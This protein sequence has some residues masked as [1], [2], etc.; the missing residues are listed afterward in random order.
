[1]TETT[2]PATWE[3]VQQ[4]ARLL[5]K[6]GVKYALIG[7]YALAAHGIV[8]FSDDIDILVAPDPE[9]T[10][11]WV[12]ALAELPDGAAAELSGEEANLW[13]GDGPLAIRINDEFTVDVMAAACGHGWTEL[14][15]FVERKLV[16]DATVFVLGL[17]GLL[18][19]K[20]GMRDRDRADAAILR[21][22][23]DAD[24]TSQ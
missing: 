3:D 7:G 9:N 19:T 5:A 15:P 13:E 12:R 14:A 8:R 22:L 20:Q 2:R 1:M 16:D 23:L 11:R 21:R 17:E 18:L 24:A 10:R 6:H 4:V